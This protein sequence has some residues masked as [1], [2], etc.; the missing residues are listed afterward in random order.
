MQIPNLPPPNVYECISVF[1]TS[2]RRAPQLRHNCWTR[3][4]AQEGVSGGGGVK[5]TEVV[6]RSP[7]SKKHKIIMIMFLE[8]YFTASPAMVLKL[9][10]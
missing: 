3:V 6:P 2:K 4:R 10:S 8:L 9:F 1:V 7:D 5:R